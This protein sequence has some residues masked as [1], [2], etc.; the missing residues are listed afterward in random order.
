M[1]SFRKLF[2]LNKKPIEAPA[3]RQEV[4][5]VYSRAAT[6]PESKL[7]FPVGRSFAEQLGYPKELLDSLPTITSESF[8]GVSNVSI[9]AEI[10]EGSVVLDI[11]CGAGLDSII[12]AGKTGE[13]G[14]VIGI[15]FS[16][17]MI[18]KARK[19]LAAAPY[20]NIEFHNASAESLPMQS[21]KFD[22]VLANGIFNLNPFRNE[23]FKEIYRVLKPGGR[24]FAA[25]IVFSKPREHPDN[26]IKINDWFA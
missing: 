21:R 20:K 13:N 23:I 6:N 22:V 26:V 25:E 7:P 16:E 1:K 19:S 17:E 8:A 2:A 24:V 3:L 11:G 14:K 15:D 10:L 4:R 5:K 9:F 12:A 18:Q